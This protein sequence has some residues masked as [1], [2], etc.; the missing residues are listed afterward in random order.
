M[1]YCKVGACLSLNNLLK[2]LKD[3]GKMQYIKTIKTQLQDVFP[4]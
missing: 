2:I 4:L 1:S 3:A